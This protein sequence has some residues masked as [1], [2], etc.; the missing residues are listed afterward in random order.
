M[1]HG[2]PYITRDRRMQLARAYAEVWTEKNPVLLEGELGLEKVTNKLKAGN[3]ING[4]NNLD[5]IT[6][7]GGGAA[8]TVVDYRSNF[9]T[10]NYVYAGYNL[11]S[12]PTITR[13]IDNTLQNAQGVVD[14]ETD[15][16]N[17][18]NLTYI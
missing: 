3:G 10:D 13:T 14:L 15:W 17:R 8:N 12:T 16:A 1:S 5:Y 18:L 9:E 4:W 7:G 11:N 6:G 2:G